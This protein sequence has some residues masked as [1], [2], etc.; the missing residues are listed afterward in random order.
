MIE[1]TEKTEKI[2]GIRHLGD[3]T[4]ACGLFTLLPGEYVITDSEALVSQIMADFPD[5]FELL[6][7]EFVFEMAKLDHIYLNHPVASFDPPA[8]IEAD[9]TERTSIS[10]EEADEQAKAIEQELA[11]EF[12]VVEKELIAAFADEEDKPNPEVDETPETVPNTEETK[13]AEPAA[14]EQEEETE[15]RR[16]GRSRKED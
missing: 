6:E 13:P 15:K 9:V 14:I 11:D 12:A 3:S 16:P 1:Q 8:V 5:R 2:K 4:Y 10:A 7:D